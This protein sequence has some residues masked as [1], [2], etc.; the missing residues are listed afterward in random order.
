MTKIDKR[1]K[2]LNPWYT[3]ANW[4]KIHLI[5]L[6]LET[7]Y[8]CFI[9]HKCFD[10]SVYHHFEPIGNVEILLIKRENK[11]KVW[12]NVCWQPTMTSVKRDSNKTLKRNA[13]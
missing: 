11:L 3:V 12:K 1:T 7:E 2:W 6:F 9:W 8:D 4:N 5:H 13:F 10:E